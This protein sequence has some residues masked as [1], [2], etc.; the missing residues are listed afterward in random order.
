VDHFQKGILLPKPGTGGAQLVDDLAS[1]FASALGPFYPLAGRL[2]ASEITDSVS[3]PNL[4]ISLCCNGE[5]TE[6]IHAV[7]PEV[8]MSHITTPVYIPSVVWS[9]FPLNRLL[10]VEAVVSSLPVLAAQVTELADGIFIGMSLNHGV[11]DGAAFWL[12]LQHL[13][14]DKSAQEGWR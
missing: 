1:S 14:R 4:A 7:A 5:G 9:F 11:A 13:V 10:N 8:T 2:T 6:F 3:S 12:F